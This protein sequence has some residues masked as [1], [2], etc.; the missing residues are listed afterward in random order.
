MT[1]WLPESPLRLLG[2]ALCSG[3]LVWKLLA[4]G[5]WWKGQLQGESLAQAFQR[6]LRRRG[7]TRQPS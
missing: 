7:L 6:E 3:W 1:T 2:L 5:R 4:V